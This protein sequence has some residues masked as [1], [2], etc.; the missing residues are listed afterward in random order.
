MYN[1]FCTHSSRP[2]AEHFLP[3]L[4]ALLER[5][6]PR[7]TIVN[8]QGRNLNLRNHWS[9]PHPLMT[10]IHA[11]LG[12]TTELYASPLN[13]DILHPSTYFSAFEEDRDFG[14]THD[15]HC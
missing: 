10:A 11:S 8:P 4:S 13:C 7:A 3:A 9:I 15:C 12:T 14:A 6:H 2:P 1:Q 5:Y